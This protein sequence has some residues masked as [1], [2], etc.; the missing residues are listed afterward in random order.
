M[1]F[2]AQICYLVI[3]VTRDERDLVLVEQSCP[4]T[5]LPPADVKKE[6][7]KG[8]LSGQLLLVFCLSCVLVWY[9]EGSGPGVLFWVPSM[10]VMA[11]AVYP[12]AENANL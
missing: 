4:Q 5:P 2:R 11:F 1:C 12:H 8:I 7:P 9:W 3:S 6:I 10:Q